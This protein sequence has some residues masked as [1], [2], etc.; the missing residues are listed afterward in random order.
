MDTPLIL[1]CPL[2]IEPI[3]NAGKYGYQELQH[4]WLIRD[5]SLK[6]ISDTICTTTA[7]TCQQDCQYCSLLQ[8]SVATTII[9]LSAHLKVTF[10]VNISVLLCKLYNSQPASCSQFCIVYA[11]KFYNTKTLYQLLILLTDAKLRTH[12]SSVNQPFPVVPHVQ[13]HTQQYTYQ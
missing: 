12:N 3:Q 10:M 6:R 8:L 9:I 11:F 13:N 5:R 4:H 1:R 7:R 2:I